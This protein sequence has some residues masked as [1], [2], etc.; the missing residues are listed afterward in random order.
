M[1]NKFE[2]MGRLT[3][4]PELRST[5]TGVSVTSFTLAVERNYKAPNGEKITDFLDFIA[6]R[7]TAEFI[8]RNFKKGRMMITAGQ[9]TTEVWT[10]SDEKKRKSVKFAVEEVYYADYKKDEATPTGNKY[11]PP[12]SAIP[13]SFEEITGARDDDLPF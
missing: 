4:D 3:A 7:K 6:W 13:E 2:I 10:D 9:V 12:N 11:S 5:G 8:C 1:M